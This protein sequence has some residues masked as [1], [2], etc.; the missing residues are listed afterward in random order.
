MAFTR[1]HYQAIASTLAVGAQ[2]ESAARDAAGGNG[3]QPIF[4]IVCELADIF[5]ADNPNFNRDRFFKAVYG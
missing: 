4:K 1:Q 5:E 2:Q 3:E